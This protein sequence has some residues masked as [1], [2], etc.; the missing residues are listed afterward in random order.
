MKRVYS[1]LLWGIFPL[2]ALQLCAEEIRL[3][4]DTAVSIALKNNINLQVER[5]DLETKERAKKTSWNEFL[6]SLNVGADLNHSEN[7]R[8]STT[9]ISGSSP[10]DFSASIKASLPLS[11]AKK[12][13]IKNRRL[14]YETGEIN[15]EDAQKQ[16]ERDVKEGFYNLIVLVE[17]IQLIEQ[18]IE[19]AQKRYDQAKTNY[20]NGLVPVLTMLSAQVTLENLKPDL[21]DVKV[22]Y[23]IAKM[24]FKQMLGIERDADITI[25]GSI[26]P[27]TVTF[28]T[29]SLI[30]ESLP[31]RFDIQSLMKSLEVLENQKKLTRAEEYTPLLSFSYSY[32]AGLNDPFH[33]DWGYLERWS[34]R[35]TFGISVSL[36]LDGLIPGSSSR[37]KIDEIDDSIEKAQIELVQAKQLARIEIE[38]IVLRLEKSSRTLKVLEQNVALAQKAYDLTEKEYN[39]GVVELLAVEEAYD[40]LEEAKL[41]VLEERYNYL[42]GL[43]DIEYALNTDLGI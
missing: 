24:Q 4:V 38:S 1:F 14:T 18:N 42:I 19:T 33:T 32:S 21:E 8:T 22:A 3:D 34:G 36:P 29:E 37:I 9:Q 31:S 43:L 2:V 35:S 15:L 17:K 25:V 12:Y 30:L 11:A 23:E 10:W 5:I 40:E 41:G 7:D 39:A 16:L 6:P 28:D 13:N 26:E 27:K 20:E